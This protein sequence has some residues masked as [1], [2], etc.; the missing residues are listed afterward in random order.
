MK[1]KLPELPEI[2]DA[3]DENASRVDRHLWLI[4]LMDW[5]SGRYQ[6]PQNVASVHA[7]IHL[8]L[9][10]LQSRPENR[11]RW[12]AW[13]RSFL[14]GIDASSLFSDHGFAPRAAFFAEF[15][16]R[17]TRKF[18]PQTPDT[19]EM[20]ELFDF[21]FPDDFDIEWLNALDED[22]L[23]RIHLLLFS[24]VIQTESPVTQSTGDISPQTPEG[25]SPNLN[26][27]ERLLM[28][29]LTYSISQIA[30]TG[31]APEIRNRMSEDAQSARAFFELPLAFE[32]FRVWVEGVGAK[33]EASIESAKDLVEHL[34]NCR[35]AAYSVYKHLDENGISVGIVFC[36]MQLR[37]R[38]LRIK[39]LI[40]CLQSENAPKE[41]VRLLIHLIRVSAERK[42]LRSLIS[43]N[44][45]LTAAKVAERTAETGE[46]Y[47]ANS[48]SEYW[49]MIKQAAGGGF[50][51][52]LTTIAKFAIISL[53]LSAFWGGV[54]AS[55]NYAISFVL[56]MLCHFTLAT[57]QPAMTAPLM[58]AKLKDWENGLG[59]D[60][61]VEQTTLLLRSQIAAII[62]NIGIVVP[63]VFVLAFFVKNA[64]FSLMTEEYALHTLHDIGLPGF[65]LL[66][67]AFTGVL[68]FLS[69]IFAGWHENWFVLNRLDSAICHNPRITRVLGKERAARWANWLKHHISG[70][71][72]NISLGFLLGLTP[73]FLDF[74]GVPLEVRHVT[75]ASGQVAAAVFTL[76]VTVLQSSDFWWAVLGILAIGPLNLGVSFYLAFRLALRA[77]NIN[78]VNRGVIQ[79]AL[80]AEWRK[81]PLSFILPRYKEAETAKKE[82]VKT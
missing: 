48:R 40:D 44:A 32:R 1:N 37:E 36:L 46:H 52:A 35:L 12:R 8:L 71:A 54:L 39:T 6:K 33:G 63:A 65:T 59:L 5:I 22:T 68:L 66:F 53:G 41:V 56:I 47:I 20:S 17:A 72:A 81:N 11:K 77:H 74:F 75:L 7:R 82:T 31:F 29:A 70:L 2:L 10:V 4:S 18:L 13:W 55:F 67:A 21:L 25:D 45:H 15:V 49:Q 61:F 69:S 42:S 64:G 80:L 57:K 3:Q 27:G 58:A 30:A 14:G 26:N 73:A 78:H 79:S 60:G 43:R 24:R 62:G 76:G 34:N 51:V 50:F 38:I 23:N 28:D 9:D 19:A 16:R